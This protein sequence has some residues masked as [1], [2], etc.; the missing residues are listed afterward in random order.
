MSALI[1]DLDALVSKPL[2]SPEDLVPEE[3]GELEVE[4]LVAT[5]TDTIIAVLIEGS[6]T[7]QLVSR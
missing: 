6:T 4:E 1:S 2:P 3:D 5:S 7:L